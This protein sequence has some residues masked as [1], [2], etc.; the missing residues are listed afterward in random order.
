MNN[1]DAIIKLLVDYHASCA[2]D[3]DAKDAFVAIEALTNI[4]ERNKS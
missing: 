4:L 3:E 2:S 1:F